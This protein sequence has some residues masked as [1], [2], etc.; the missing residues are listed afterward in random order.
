MKR[1]I[2]E[3]KGA[4]ITP[5]S[6]INEIYKTIRGVLRPEQLVANQ[7]KIVKNGKEIDNPKELSEEFATFFIDKVDGIVEEIKAQIEQTIFKC[8]TCS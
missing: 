6:T 5:K 4:A 3:Q 8:K 7:L 1:K 2:I